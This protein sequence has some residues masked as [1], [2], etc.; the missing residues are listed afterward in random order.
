MFTYPG[1]YCR[2]EACQCSDMPGY[3]FGVVVHHPPSENVVFRNPDR[4]ACS[5]LFSNS[6]PPHGRVHRHFSAPRTL[7][8]CLP[9]MPPRR[10]GLRRSCGR[11]H[12]GGDPCFRSL[13]LGC[14]P[15]LCAGCQSH[16]RRPCICCHNSSVWS[17]R[18]LLVYY[19]FP[20]SLLTPHIPTVS[21]PSYFGWGERRISNT[22]RYRTFV[23]DPDPLT[24]H[25]RICL[26][27]CFLYQLNV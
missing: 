14:S 2:F 1:T 8:H 12:G 22:L 6:L 9:S 3:L 10:R 19:Y 21:L 20:F 17:L 24:K 7:E 16:P 18:T 13:D 26:G 15:C 4:Q 11:R 25:H 5:C 23:A 27:C